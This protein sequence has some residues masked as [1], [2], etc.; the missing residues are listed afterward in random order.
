MCFRET[1]TS[2]ARRK[3]T[4]FTLIELLVV[5]GIITVLAGLLLPAL[6]RAKAR[7]LSLVCMNHTKQLALAVFLYAVDNNDR[8]VYNLEANPRKPL[9][10]AL[11]EKNWVNNVLNWELDAANTNTAFVLK[12][13]LGNYIER[14]VRLFKCPADRA[15][16]PLQRKAG[17]TERVRSFSMNAMAGDAGPNVKRNWNVLNPRYR[18]F[19]K[20]GDMPQPS[21]IFLFIDEHPDSIGD[22]YFINRGDDRTWVHLPASYHNGAANL[23]FAD[24]H[25]ESHRWIDRSTKAPAKPEAVLLPMPILA[26]DGAD[27]EWLTQ[28]SSIED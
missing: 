20:W 14:N 10:P 5:I 17:W 18:Q 21:Q 13:P 25:T 16:S 4:G 23:S 24:G 12:T 28:H 1:S 7:S 3:G 19:L 26:P 2:S 6:G 11:F 15:L 22:G 27:F 9:D 8:L